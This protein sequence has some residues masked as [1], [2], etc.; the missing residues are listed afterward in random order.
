MSCFPWRR[1]W[2][3]FLLVWIITTVAEIDSRQCYFPSGIP[4][5]GTP[6]FPEG[7]QSVCCTPGFT[8]LSNKI[9]QP[10]PVGWNEK[11]YKH[12]LY[13]SGCTDK[14]FKDPACPQFCIGSRF[15][16]NVVNTEEQT[17][18]VDRG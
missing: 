3:L 7:K 11:P 4:S 1:P 15:D 14:D 5:P 13:R 17:D 9:C 8:C 10:G 2:W 18:P 6:C 12:S 16:E